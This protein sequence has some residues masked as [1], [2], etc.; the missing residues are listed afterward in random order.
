MIYLPNTIYIASIITYMYNNKLVML[1]Y[2]QARDN[3]IVTQ[4]SY[5]YAQDFYKILKHLQYLQKWKYQI[6]DRFLDKLCSTKTLVLG[7][8]L[9]GSIPKNKSRKT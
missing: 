5:K 3:Q 9:L 4:M 7:I 1:P 8:S 6:K 2:T